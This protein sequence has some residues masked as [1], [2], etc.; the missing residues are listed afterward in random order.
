MK[1]KNIRRS[2]G[3]WLGLTALVFVVCHILFPDTVTENLLYGLNYPL[4]WVVN[5]LFPR[6]LYPLAE[7]VAFTPAQALLMR[8]PYFILFIL[9]WAGFGGIVDLALGRAK[10]G[11][12]KK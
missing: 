9:T 5:L 1:L 3:F 7:G 8:A 11:K 10:R 12:R 2:F 4:Y 6:L